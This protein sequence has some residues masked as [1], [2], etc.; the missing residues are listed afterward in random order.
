MMILMFVNGNQS[1]VP[2]IFI[3]LEA[4]VLEAKVFLPV[5]FIS[6]TRM[7]FRSKYIKSV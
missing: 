2:L 4:K 6:S 1:L 3:I 7:A 5:N